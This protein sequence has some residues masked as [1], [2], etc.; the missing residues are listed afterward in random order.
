MN[1]GFVLGVGQCKSGDRCP[2]FLGRW[3]QLDAISHFYPELGIYQLA[4][5]YFANPFLLKDLCSAGLLGWDSLHRLWCPPC[6]LQA[7][8]GRC[9]GGNGVAQ[10]GEV[11][12]KMC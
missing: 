6:C 3:A 9:S 4:I 7:L 8:L 1:E 10:S 12:I 2:P 11:K 5:Y